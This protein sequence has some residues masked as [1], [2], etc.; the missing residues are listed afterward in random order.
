MES[1]AYMITIEIPDPCVCC[2][3]PTT[4]ISSTSYTTIPNNPRPKVPKSTLSPCHVAVGEGNMDFRSVWEAFNR[5]LTV[6]LFSSSSHSADEPKMLLNKDI[7]QFIDFLSEPGSSLLYGRLSKEQ[8]LIPCRVSGIIQCTN[9]S[10]IIL[11]Y[12]FKSFL[13]SQVD[14]I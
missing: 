10:P 11:I 5:L 4:G 12:M 7:S 2:I 13:Y 6:M 3:I 8:V 14:T 1:W 9:N